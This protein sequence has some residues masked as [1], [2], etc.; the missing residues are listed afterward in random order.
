MAIQDIGTAS[1]S[2]KLVYSS[3][4]ADKVGKEFAALKQQT[5][6]NVTAFGKFADK[7]GIQ[8]TAMTR[9]LNI[10]KEVAN[11]SKTMRLMEVA[12]TNARTNT[13]STTKQIVQ[14]EAAVAQSRKSL[15]AMTAVAAMAEKR[16]PMEM[17]KA[18]QLSAASFSAEFGSKGS[19]LFSGAMT[20]V[21]Q[22][23]ALAL[24]VALKA[25]VG[26]ALT[27]LAAAAAGIGTVLFK[28][29]QRLEALDAAAFK[30]KAL[31][32]NTGQI[33]TI[34]AE[35]NEAVIGTT[36]SLDAMA[37]VAAQAFTAGIKPGK[38]MLD[39][40]NAVANAAA[41]GGVP[42]EQV[43][44]YLNQAATSGK[45]MG[46][47]LRYLRQYIPITQWLAKSL[48]VTTQEVENMVSAGK[49]GIP[50]L[51][52]AINENA[53]N[54]AKTMGGAIKTS[55]ENLLTA[56]ARLGAAFLQPIFGN[57]DGE[58]GT[59]SKAIQ[60]ITSSIDKLKNYLGAHK[61]AL[62]TFWEVMGRGAIIAGH[63]IIAVC[64]ELV[65]AYRD[66]G[67]AAGDIIGAALRGFAAVARA[68]AATQDFLGRPD[69]A[70]A[71][72]KRADEWDRLADSAFGLG[73][74]TEGT[75]QQL[76]KA[77]DALDKSDQKLQSWGDKARN[78]THQVENLGE[79]TEDTTPQFISLSEAFKKLEIT[80]DNVSKGITGSNKDFQ[81]LLKTMREKKAPQELIDT[82]TR[83]RKQFDESGRGAKSLGDA[84]ANLGD[85]SLSA[86]DRADQLI[87]SLKQLGILPGEAEDAMAGLNEQ[88]EQYTAYGAKLAEPLDVFGSGLIQANGYINTT[89]KN[90]AKLNEVVTGLRKSMYEA[91]AAGQDPAS[92]WQQTHDALLM[93]LADFGITGDAAENLINTY[94]LPE[95]KFVL[96]FESAGKPAVQQQ[97]DALLLQIDQA[98]K[99]GK[100]QI[101]LQVGTDPKAAQDV[102]NFTDQL[103]LQW[104]QYDPLTG[105]VT[106]TIP[107]GTD[108]DALKNGIESIL[109]KS[110]AEIESI[111]KFPPVDQNKIAKDATGAD[112]DN[113]LKIPAVL[114]FQGQNQQGG[115]TGNEQ[116]APLGTGLNQNVPPPPGF[117]G[118]PP[119]GPPPF[120]GSDVAPA[121]VDSGGINRTVTLPEP[122][123]TWDEVN[124]I[125]TQNPD[126]ATALGDWAADAQSRGLSFSQAFAEGIESGSPLIVEAV[127]R[128]AEIATGGLGSSPAKYG[129]LS[130]QG[131]TFFR[132]QRFTQAY[133]EGIAS[134]ASSVQEASGTIARSGAAPLGSSLAGLL[135]D[136]SELGD[137]G[138]GVWDLAEAIGNITFSVMGLANNL[139][140]GKLFPKTYR[141]DPDWWKN[142]RSRGERDRQ[143]G[144]NSNAAAIPANNAAAIIPANSTR[145]QRID[146]II[147]EGRRRGL[148]DDEIAGV[149]SVAQQESDFGPEGF[150]G[151]SNQTVDTGYT[152]GAPYANDP[153]KAL[154]KFYDNYMAGGYGQGGGPA[155]KEAAL[156]ALRQGDPGPFLNWLQYG[157]QGLPNNEGLNASFGP[158]VRR[159][160][161]QWRRNMPAN[162]TNASFFAPGGGAGNFLPP[163]SILTNDKGYTSQ[164]ISQ[165][166][167]ALVAQLFPGIKTIGGGG[168]RPGHEGTHDV[169]LSIDVMI[170]NPDTAEGKALGDRVNAFIRAN[171]EQLGVLYTI[172]QDTWQDFKG[173]PPTTVGGHMDHIDIHFAAGAVPNLS[174][175]NLNGVNGQNISL[176]GPGQQPEENP[177]WG[178]P[179]PP[180]IQPMGPQHGTQPPGWLP[181]PDPLQANTDA[182]NNNTDS[183]N[184][185]TESNLGVP[186]ALRPLMEQD[187]Q[188]RD[189]VEAARRG[190]IPAENVEPLLQHID[191]LIYDQNQLNTADGKS[192]A[193]WLSTLKGDIES[194][195]G[196]TEG[197]S[198]LEQAQ[199]MVGQFG[200]L[201]GSGFQIFQS[202]LDSISAAKDIGDI[203]ARGIANTE[204]VYNII[205]RGQKF[206]ELATN[207]ATFTGNVLQMVGGIVQ[208]AGAGAA[209]GG[210]M[211]ATSAAGMA[212][213][214]A[215]SISQIVSQVMAAINA[216]IDL[217]QAAYRI[218]TKY[219]GRFLESWLGLPGATD[220]QFLL[221][222]MTGQLMAYT[223]ENPEKKTILN[224]LGRELGFSGGQTRP[225]PNNIFYIYQGPGQ[226][227]RD[228][229]NDAMFAIKSSNVGAFGYE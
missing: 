214:A 165:T 8:G 7:L 226:D 160:Y 80:T 60:S 146:A 164:P 179:R 174:E 111:L 44:Y 19:A 175:L 143:R 14:A 222:T 141:R 104:D 86:S 204:D 223:S 178:N 33:K 93:I 68:Y 32:A 206:L 124:Q 173:N 182:L 126:L 193:D 188:L 49:I 183:T 153:N 77:D 129:P 98:K 156:Q 90:G 79:T 45:L 17:A 149:L 21:G 229:M 122:A 227:P 212:I 1:G 71:E 102:K 4:G 118:R 65:K 84:I 94:L 210:D 113:P 121:P 43:A 99:D 20:K 131:W 134:Q 37:S 82:V 205:E 116:G 61:E 114:D 26:I 70:K 27:G 191:G 11:A 130:G 103:G 228:T 115:T 196:V 167:A 106:L 187:P 194:R 125:I 139:S 85:K 163:P 201:V 101:Q 219:L 108:L 220:V 22:V 53:G 136:L 128:L 216:V 73:E 207:I 35:V 185:N 56:V 203:L 224:T 112:K 41:A 81:E 176:W 202:V 211:G 110:P 30:M 144:I 177:V 57:A 127:K 100:N 148:S 159:F 92:V 89:S 172:W 74:N 67:G 72:R 87:S 62:I 168:A 169:G 197:P 25:G 123:P 186:E 39:F 170:P 13:L 158:N 135:K 152:G 105:N 166:S 91:A 215:G 195:Y 16:L 88:I 147:A 40:L 10:Q 161:P 83:L 151:F 190:S 157:V 34:M 107:P 198:M 137:F 50:E 48:H 28:G 64:K 209:A 24:G 154:Q 6:G 199:D 52:K 18:G 218:G 23:G 200:G 12:A 162:A 150:L 171:H 75:L 42:L 132:G 189:A 145:Q 63:I 59:V 221:D 54:A 31:G 46:E 119:V 76:D 95:H 51:T 217:V 47:D 9:Y 142:A 55:I 133:A 29:F 97:L 140:G 192:T 181:G 36:F 2:V 120:P 180:D 155:A 69:K 38:Q 225:S 184:Q 3:T 78:A 117:R 15:A 138:R 208:G 96:T 66:V 109:G 213:S 58:A 5:E